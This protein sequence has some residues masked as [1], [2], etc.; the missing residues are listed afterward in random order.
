MCSDRRLPPLPTKL[1]AHVFRRS[2]ITLMLEAGAPPSY[3]QEQVG[4]EDASTTLNI[5]ARVLRK[6]DRRSFGRAFDE[7]MTG[8]VP[9]SPFDRREAG[10]AQLRLA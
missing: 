7:L 4:H 1:T 8:A 5:Y 3:V 6:R 10:Q 9:E 2:Y